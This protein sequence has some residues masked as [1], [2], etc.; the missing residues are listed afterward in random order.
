MTTKKTV[1]LA[2]LDARKASST[3][4]EFEYMLNGIDHTGVFLTVL[5]AQDDGVSSFVNQKADEQRQRTAILEQRNKGSR[6]QSADYTPIADDLTL[7]AELA[8]KRLIGWR[9]LDD[10]FTPANALMLCGINSELAQQVLEHSND[11]GNFLKL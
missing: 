7:G 3:G 9:G 4:S 6:A 11:M 8:A 10:E 5:G 2:S 1:S